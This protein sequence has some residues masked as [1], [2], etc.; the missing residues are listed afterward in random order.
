MTGNEVSGQS[1]I[2]HFDAETTQFILR[3]PREIKQ[4]EAFEIFPTTGANWRIRSNTIT[5]CQTPV[6]LDSYGSETSIFEGNTITRGKVAGVKA[7]A[8]IHGWFQIIG[9]TISGFDEDGSA[10]LSLYADRAGRNLPLL[11]TRNV[12]ENCAIPVAATAPDMWT[13]EMARDNLFVN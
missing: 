9:N 6:L 7:A 2:D 11:C 12:F 4:G 1:V 10:A 5:G 8:Q 3:E 13:D